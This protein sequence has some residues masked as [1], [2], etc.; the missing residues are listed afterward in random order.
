MCNKKV[1][2]AF[3]L[4]ELLVA[5]AIIGILSILGY[6]LYS[7]AKRAARNTARESSLTEI[8]GFLEDYEMR[9]R[10]RPTT[11]EFNSTAYT[12]TFSTV[13]PGE[14]AAYDMTRISDITDLQKTTNC[15]CTS[16]P[17]NQL[18]IIYNYADQSLGVCLEP[19]GTKV[20]SGCNTV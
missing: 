18:K 10:K 9:F 7:V 13:N 4:V 12:V 1:K 6:A 17:K 8:S 2:K 3:T 19:N 16:I 20:I 15:A 14:T 5:I 11:I